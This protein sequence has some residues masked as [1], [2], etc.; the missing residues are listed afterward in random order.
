MNALVE[1]FERGEVESFHHRDHIRMAWSYLKEMGFAEG[2]RRFTEALQR[3]AA[4]NGQ[5]QLYHA[6]ITWAYIVAINERIERDP[7]RQWND[8]AR[9]NEELFAWKPSMLDAL[10]RP[11]TLA[12]DFARRVFLLPDAHHFGVL[13]LAKS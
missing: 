9:D 1:A 3:F 2:A 8:F 4:K 7:E 10:Y 5:P 13:Q 6:T 11:E 12:S